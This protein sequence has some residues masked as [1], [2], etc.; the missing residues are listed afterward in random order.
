[1]EEVER[2]KDVEL[3]HNGYDV[4]CRVC[5]RKIELWYNGGELDWQ[6]CCGF[7]YSIEIGRIDY[8]VKRDYEPEPKPTGPGRVV[9]AAGA[10][11]ECGAEGKL[12][13][14]GTVLR[15]LA[16]FREWRVENPVDWTERVLQP[17]PIL[18]VNGVPVARPSAEAVD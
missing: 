14:V 5:G 10:C 12:E 2:I 11:P 13:I 7:V 3:T 15:C 18:F 17:E 9:M 6:L 4:A 8:V 1:M 16:C